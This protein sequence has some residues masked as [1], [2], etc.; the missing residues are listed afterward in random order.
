MT[1]DLSSDRLRALA[2]LDE[3]FTSFTAGGRS[4]RL[5]HRM[6]K[7]AGQLGHAGYPMLAWLEAW[8]PIRVSELAE[9]LS[10]DASTVSRRV[11]DLQDKGLVARAVDLEDQRASLVELTP[12]GLQLLADL[13]EARRRLLDDAL[14]DW[15]A[16]EVQ[17]LADMLRRLT[18]AFDRLR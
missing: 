9:R 10:L 4:A 14:A 5:H 2:E 12:Q 7:A 6:G 16:G 18:K 13:R 1:V 3:A 11:A 8:G 15:P 17:A